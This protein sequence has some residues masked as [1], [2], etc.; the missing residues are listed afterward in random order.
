[1]EEN[2]LYGV[3]PVHDIWRGG[4]GGTAAGAVL[5]HGGSYNATGSGLP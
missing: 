5:R 4:L 1:M 2:C 3:V